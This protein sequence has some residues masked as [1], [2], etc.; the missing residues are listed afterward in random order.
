AG[1]TVLVWDHICTIDQE[2]KF[3]WT[4]PRSVVKYLFLLNRYV[5]PIGQAVA[6]FYMS[7]LV[8]LSDLSSVNHSPA[9]YSTS[10]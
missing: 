9:K 1:F 5:T 4:A 8:V 2:I 7:R 3:W 10:T 6:V